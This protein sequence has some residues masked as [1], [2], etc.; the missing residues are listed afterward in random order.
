MKKKLL[1]LC[2]LY[3][4]EKANPYPQSEKWDPE[5]YLKFQIWEAERSVVES[6]G[7]WFTAWEIRYKKPI[8][9]DV[10]EE[11]IYKLATSDMLKKIARDDIDFMSMYFK[12]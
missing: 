3:H 6:P 5:Q 10:K 2:K 11:E 8:P 4:Q 12:L 1:E 7:Y 9:Q